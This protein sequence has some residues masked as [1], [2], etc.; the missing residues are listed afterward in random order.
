MPGRDVGYE[1]AS[2]L[3]TG[4]RARGFPELSMHSSYRVFHEPA[5]ARSPW[6]GS[7]DGLAARALTPTAR[8]RQKE[9]TSPKFDFLDSVPESLLSHSPG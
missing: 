9:E 7:R 3:V 5:V 4:Q 8:P 6:L 1:P 2:S